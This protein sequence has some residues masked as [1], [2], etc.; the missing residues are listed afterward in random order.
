MQQVSLAA[1]HVLIEIGEQGLLILT[2]GIPHVVPRH[3]LGVTT[4]Y[5][6]HEIL[7]ERDDDERRP[8]LSSLEVSALST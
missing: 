3:T 4:R 8:I 2:Q 1:M 6:F 7:R 5:K